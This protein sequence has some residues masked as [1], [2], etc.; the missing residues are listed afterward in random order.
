MWSVS[1]LMT[2]VLRKLSGW[3]VDYNLCKDTFVNIKGKKHFPSLSILVASIAHFIFILPSS[4]IIA[5]PTFSFALFFL[6]HLSLLFIC[7]WDTNYI[8]FIPFREKNRIYTLALPW[9]LTVI[10]LVLALFSI[11]TYVYTIIRSD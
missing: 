3:T 7:T 2:Q 4:W 9:R 8:F 6:S 5:V 10:N 1:P 11:R